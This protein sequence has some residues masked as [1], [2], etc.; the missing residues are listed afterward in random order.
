MITLAAVRP[1]KPVLIPQQ[2]RVKNIMTKWNKSMK[3]A[4]HIV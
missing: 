2:I 4:E 3:K 1:Q